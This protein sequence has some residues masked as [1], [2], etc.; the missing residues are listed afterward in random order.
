MSAETTEQKS[1]KT[2]LELSKDI[3]YGKEKILFGLTD[4]AKTVIDQYVVNAKY[5][6][7]IPLV[8]VIVSI[9]KADWDEIKA[10]IQ[11]CSG[12]NWQQ[13]SNYVRDGIKEMELKEEILKSLR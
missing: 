11:I 8:D 1:I 13:I 5:P 3:T 10:F 12:T 7:N 2:Q 4:L 6:N 9:P